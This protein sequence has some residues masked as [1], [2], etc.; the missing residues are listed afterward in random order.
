LLHPLS[1]KFK[2]APRS[3]L[4]RSHSSS[5]HTSFL[6]PAD[7][8]TLSYCFILWRTFI[9]VYL[10][11]LDTACRDNVADFRSSLNQVT[12]DCL[13]SQVLSV[14]AFRW[15]EP[16]LKLTVVASAVGQIQTGSKV[17]TSKV[18]F[19]IAN[20]FLV[21]ADSS[22]LSYCFILWRTFIPVYLFALDTACRDNV[23]DFR[24][25]LNQVTA[26]C[27][28][29]QVLSVGAFRWIEPVLKL[30]VVASAVG[31]IQT[32]SKVVTSK[33]AFLIA[34]YFLVPADS[35]TLSY[36]FILWR[37]FIP[38]YLFA[39]DTACRDNV[40]DFRSSLNQVTADCLYSQ[41]LSVGAFR[42]IEPVLK[43]TVV[44]SAALNVQTGSKVAFLT[45]NY[46]FVP[47]VIRT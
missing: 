30:T 23:A 42:W 6:V 1:A 33:V 2:L 22:T 3:S 10:F 36:C 31:Q 16:V 13:Y 18:A 17:V 26:D 38:V 41:V 34:N 11:A 25:S 4:P 24:S 7:S 21:P 19:L 29:S 40:A 45:A 39:L 9:P 32:G 35:S 47:A 28:Y 43:L 14:G 44:A 20:Y 15:I 8:S 5:P 27:L 12:A 46:L 37:T